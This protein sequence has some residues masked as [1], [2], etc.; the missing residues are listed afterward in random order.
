NF[1]YRT[2]DGANGF[3]PATL[4]DP[5]NDP[6]W[7][8]FQTGSGQTYRGTATSFYAEIPNVTG[9]F[10]ANRSIY[11]T[12]FGDGRLFRRDFAPDTQTSSISTQVTGGV[13]SPV[14]NV[15]TSGGS[16]V[17]D[18]SDAT[19]MFVANG[20]LWFSRKDG[21]LYQASW[22]GTSV[23]SDATLDAAATGTNWSGRALFLAPGGAAPPPPQQ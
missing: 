8:Q 23:T 11:Y 14:E 13:I 5:Y 9:M 1:Y 12:L 2:W 15:V 18:F 4:V 7:D 6:Y 10:Y 21:N 3:G 22:N 19:G 17:P 20:T 16:G